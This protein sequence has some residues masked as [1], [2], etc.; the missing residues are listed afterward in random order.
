M[1]VL[2]ALLVHT[3]IALDCL[4]PLDCARVGTIVLKGL[5][6]LTIQTISAK[7]GISVPKEPLSL[8]LVDHS[9][10]KI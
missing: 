7:L 10:T 2:Y 1:R 6:H 4:N 3:V 8:Q 9:L 5:N